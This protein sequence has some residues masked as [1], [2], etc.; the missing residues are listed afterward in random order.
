MNLNILQ[1][2][3]NTTSN[4][5]SVLCQKI[6]A[7]MPLSNKIELYTNRINLNILTSTYL[8]YDI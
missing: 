8:Q 1:H 4:T 7:V 5:M 2:I 6:S 3:Y